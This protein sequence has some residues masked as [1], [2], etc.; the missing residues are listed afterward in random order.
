VTGFVVR[1]VVLLAVRPVSPPRRATVSAS[2]SFSVIISRGHGIH[3][4]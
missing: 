2:P 1:F 3:L 4:P